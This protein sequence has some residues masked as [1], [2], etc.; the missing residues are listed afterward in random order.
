MT[1]TAHRDNRFEY[2]DDV[3]RFIEENQCEACYFR[4]TWYEWG[5]DFAQD[6]PMCPEIEAP[7]SLEE[8]VAELDDK[9]SAGVVCSKFKLGD[10]P[11]PVDPDQLV[12]GE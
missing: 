2:V 10:V 12:L 3:I 9:G 6:Y 7:L 5:G 4:K 11:P 8:P 1:Y